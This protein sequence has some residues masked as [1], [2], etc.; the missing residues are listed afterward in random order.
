MFELL[1]LLLLAG[2]AGIVVLGFICVLW[3]VKVVFKIAL[4]PLV[5]LGGLFKFFL[6]V[7]AFVLVLTLGLPFLALL[8]LLAPLLLIGLFFWGGVCALGAVA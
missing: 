4:I 2:V 8:L 1:G 5:L 6:G 7:L 3:A